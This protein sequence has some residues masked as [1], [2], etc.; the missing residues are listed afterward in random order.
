M[1]GSC[2]HGGYPH[3]VSTSNDVIA[4]DAMETLVDKTLGFRQGGG[5]AGDPAQSRPRHPVIAKFP[6]RQFPLTVRSHGGFPAEIQKSGA[7]IRFGV[8]RRLADSEYSPTDRRM[9]AT[10]IPVDAMVT[11]F[12]GTTAVRRRIESDAPDVSFNRGPPTSVP[13]PVREG[14]DKRNIITAWKPNRD[15][16][17]PKQVPEPRDVRVGGVG[18]DTTGPASD[19]RI[20]LAC[21]EN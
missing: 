14:S 4:V 11:I 13:A 18:G 6:A 5:L 3:A 10:R 15:G 17:V 20:F 1:C 8:A 9:R 2:P 12:R 21:G 19:C 7:L 16:A